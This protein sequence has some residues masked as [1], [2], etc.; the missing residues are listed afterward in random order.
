MTKNTSNTPSNSEEL[1]QILQSLQPK[2]ETSL[3]NIKY[4]IYARKSTDDPKKQITTIEDQ[5]RICTEMAKIMGLKVVKVIEERQSAK[6][7]DIRPKFREMIEELK[8]AK[9]HGIISWHPDRLSRNMKEAG[10]IIDLLDKHTILDLKFKTM[11]FENSP[12]GKMLLGI[13]FV[14]SKEYSDKLSVDVSRGNDEKVRIGKSINK[15]KH[16]YYKDALGYLRPDGENFLLIQTAFQMRLAGKT[17]VEIAEFLNESGYTRRNGEGG[18]VYRRMDK[19]KVEKLLK[20]PLYAGVMTYGKSVVHLESQ[21][22]FIPAV[23]VAD[24]M[25]INHLDKDGLIKL[26][27]M[28]RTGEDSKA[29]LLREKVLCYK[30]KEATEPGIS[31]GSKGVN[32]FYFRCRNDECDRYNESTRAKVVIGFV[33][34][35]LKN[36]PFSTPESFAHY[37]NEMDRIRKFRNHDDRSALTTIS[38]QKGRLETRLEEIKTELLAEQDQATKEIWRNDMKVLMAQIRQSEI[39]ITN[40]KATYTDNKI[41]EIEDYRKFCELFQKLSENMAFI[42]KTG[43]LDYVIG[44][45]FANLTVSQKKVE[46]YKLNPPF[47]LLENLKVLN[48]AAVSTFLELTPTD[49]IEYISNLQTSIDDFVQTMKSCQNSKAIR[50]PFVIQNLIY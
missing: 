36:N 8:N 34:N 40:A 43:S 24:F 19:Q 1:A 22:D 28:P 25:K 3:E 17:M 20:D 32:Y 30:C 29:N 23:S 27:K 39:D 5:I 37:K 14:M 42:D 47:D 12:S 31:K 33:T 44:R 41:V 13:L 18:K 6:H 50:S 45:I 15:T 11:H 46:N 16:G 9:Y 21:Y 4:V 2:S 10:E 26:L 49:R 7:P 48:G 38:Q 35:Y